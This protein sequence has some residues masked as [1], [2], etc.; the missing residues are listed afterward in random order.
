MVLNMPELKEIFIS[1]AREFNVATF[2]L[3]A[4]MGTGAWVAWK[5]QQ[6]SDFDFAEMLRDPVTHK[7]SS[8][9]LAMFVSLAL[10][11]W[12]LVYATLNATLSPFR[13]ILFNVFLSFVGIWSGAKIIEKAIDV[14][15]AVK[16]VPLT[17]N[18][19]ENPPAHTPPPAPAPPL[20][21][22]VTPIVP[23]DKP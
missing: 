1:L 20:S 2:V 6:R 21:Y 15:A 9:R 23:K 13:E 5:S 22:T 3:L 12:F 14:Y 4:L 17:P 19:M 18:L 7:A 16:G 11:S 10:S 8:N